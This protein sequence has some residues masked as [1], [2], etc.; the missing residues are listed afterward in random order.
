MPTSLPGSRSDR[1]RRVAAPSLALV[2]TG[3]AGWLT[4]CD[5]GS[6]PA[7]QPG[8]MVALVVDH[9]TATVATAVPAPPAVRVLSK[10]GKPMARRE[11]LFSVVEGGG[12][13]VAGEQVTDGEGVARV[14]SWVLGSAAGE[15][16]L[17]VRVPELA[18]LVFTAE[19]VAASPST[20]T[21]L[22]GQ[23]REGVVGSEVSP[24]PAVLVRDAY[25]N[26]VRGAAVR[27][28]VTFGGGAVEGGNAQ[29]DAEGIARVVSW[30]LGT[31]P[32]PNVL[33]ASVVGLPA[34]ILV[35]S[36][37][38]DAPAVVTAFQGDG[39]TATVG[40][41]VP[42]PPSVRV[43]D[44]FGNLLQGVPV[45]FEAA[46]GNGVV[47]GE[48]AV[49]DAWGIAALGS[50]TLGTT[51]GPQALLVKVEGLDPVTLSAQAMAGAPTA[52]RIQ[53]GDDQVGTVGTRL[54][55]SPSVLVQ[56]DYGNPVPGIAVT[57]SETGWT[58]P[59]GAGG[60]S[61]PDPRAVGRSLRGQGASEGLDAL[62]GRNAVTDS[63]GIAAVESWTLGT[64]AGRYQLTALVSGIGA[65]LL[66]SA[67]ALPDVPWSLEKVQGDGQS[68]RAGT[69]VSVL[70]SVTV[71]DRYG[72]AVGET[73]VVFQVS[74]GAGSVTGDTARTG[75]DGVAT[76]GSWTLGPDPG[77]N[78][79]SA[80]VPGL[81]PV[82]FLAT[83]LAA[84]PA[85]I[86]KIAGDNQAAPV[87]T[88]LSVRPSVR[89]TDSQGQGIPLVAVEF[90]VALGQGSITGET[91]VTDGE[92]VAEVG[93]W[94]LGTTAGVNSL[95]ALVNGVDPVTFTATG[96]PGPP[97]SM[98]VHDG[99]GQAAQVG[100]VVAIPPSV[101][102]RDAFANPIPGVE[103]AF[104]V[105]SGQG[106]V[107]GTPSRT[108]PGGI[109]A[110][111]TWRLGPDP[112]ANSLVAT[113]AGV[114]GVVFTATATADA[115]V[116]EFAIEIQFM[117]SVDAAQEGTFRGA[118]ARWQEV[119]VGDVPD[120]TGGLPAGGCQPVAEPGGVDDV[121][122]YV[123]VLPIDGVG[124]VLGQAGPCYIWN[125][126][127]RVLPITGIMRL[128]E[129][130]LAEMHAKGILGDVIVHEMGHV[131]GIGTLWSVSPNDFLVGGGTSDP[132]FS[133]GAAVAAFDAAGGGSRTGSKVPVE[134][135]GGSGTRDAHWRESVHNAELMTGWIEAP[136]TPNPLSA[137]TIASL[138]DLGYLVNMA[139][140]DPYTLYDPLAAFRLDTGS[141]VFLNELPPPTPIFIPPPGGS[142]L[143]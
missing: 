117:T 141:R 120:F 55:A 62:N 16:V 38:A 60:V 82:T 77:P 101:R 14:G 91:V 15:N 79:L 99:D 21:L 122:I 76:V 89:V 84:I 57:F 29:T 49:T 19:A 128:D 17:E 94:T 37:V 74:G 28:E 142:R 59:V 52:A 138:A 22:D 50:W 30:T 23:E 83:G 2:L 10:K 93:S 32:G 7:P 90:R 127:G 86:G 48:N 63:S 108:G 20:L 88:A 116:S 92:G 44:R 119:I 24:P 45:A 39:Q 26:P 133:G 67:L 9:Q 69:P 137:I 43:A 51:A 124:G 12:R 35:A 61:V 95:Q 41:Q 136:G 96:I 11:V 31:A 103:V 27:F 33:T 104:S 115:P 102:V 72:N 81:A 53:G 64:V 46:P 80:S 97:A 47:T 140:A 13:V 42:L 129:A 58:A 56:D 5:L 112:G 123:S 75:A 126:D 109:A 18:P 143:P 111:T 4:A 106:S 130:D 73:E 134:N 71:G 131:L 113:A 118:A 8:S 100:A 132:Y 1:Q 121:K 6:G 114:D 85:A 66:F 70:P 105:T 65:P 139:A 135:T 125:P 98:T 110:V 36:A 78:A 34:A 3:L 87:G 25:G 107:T 54:E 68:A 40:S